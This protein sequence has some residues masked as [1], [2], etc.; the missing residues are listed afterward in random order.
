[1]SFYGN[2]YNYTAE[3]FA[4]IMLKNFG[5]N[6]KTT[7]LSGSNYDQVTSDKCSNINAQHR[8][9]GLGVYSGNHWIRLVKSKDDDIFYILHG[10]PVSDREED[11]KTYINPINVKT[12]E[13][14]SFSEGEI[15]Q[16]LNF[17]D[18]LI[19]PQ[20]EYDAA[21]HIVFSNADASCY[22]LPLNPNETLQLEVDELEKRM[23]DIDAEWDKKIKEIKAVEDEVKN[24]QSSLQDSLIDQQL[25]T[26]AVKAANDAVESIDTFVNPS[27]Y[28]L[29]QIEADLKNKE[30]QIN[31]LIEK[32]NEL[33]SK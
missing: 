8:D 23:N 24:I 6:N 25:V 11:E 4:T 13:N 30:E 33:S 7:Q 17:G 14:A 5:L 32:V 9:T 28:R 21:G 2:I 26:E 10:E 1:M 16:S 18:Y 31:E 27:Y 15:V 22:Q 12:P 20:I 3:S 19:V 29:G